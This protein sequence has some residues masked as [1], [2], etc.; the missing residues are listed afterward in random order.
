[1]LNRMTVSPSIAV[2]VDR[3]M[4]RKLQE[5]FPSSLLS[6]RTDWLDLAFSDLESSPVA[7]IVDPKLL[8]AEHRIETLRHLGTRRRAPVIVYFRMSPQMAPILLEVGQLGVRQA[9]LF[10]CD[11]DPP[12]IRAVLAAAI[13]DARNRLPEPVKPRPSPKPR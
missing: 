10:G 11:D 6:I 5:A 9:L 3:G 7:F 8:S 2:L 1:M 12:V 13:V 4:L